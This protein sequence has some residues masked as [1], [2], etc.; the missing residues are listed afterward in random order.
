M[1]HT[2]IS[3]ETL[4]AYALGELEEPERSRVDLHV[5]SNARARRQVEEV[6]ATARLLREEL[7]KEPVVELT[8]AQR[9]AIAA[10]P[11]PSP[12]AM[13]RSRWLWSGIAATLLLA[14]GTAWVLMPSLNRAREEISP[15][16]LAAMREQ[17]QQ[18]RQL[19]DQ[20]RR[21][22]VG[23]EE[24]PLYQYNEFL[25]RARPTTGEGS[26]LLHRL[27]PGAT[28]APG[29]AISA[30]SASDGSDPDWR[31]R[32]TPGE[33]GSNTEAYGRIVD[34]GFLPVA[35]SPLSTF[36]I[37]VD[38]ASYSNVRRFLTQNALPPKDAVRIEEMVNY[39]PYSYAPPKAGD[40][41]PFAAHIEVAGC[42]WNGQNRLVRIGLKGREIDAQK[43]PPTNL[44][45]LVDVSGSMA[46]DNKLP[47]VKRGLRMLVERLGENDRVAIVVYAG[48][49]GTVL[50]ST[51]GDQ[52]GTIVGAIEA[53]GAGGST[54]GAGGIEAAYDAAVRNF[55]P[56]GVNRVILCT[57][58]DFNVGITDIESL[59]R[60]I[61]AKA[62]T[63]VFLSVLGFGMGNLKDATMEKLADKGNGNYAYVDT[64]QEAR[65]VLV[66]QMSG[67]LVTIA[68]DVKV[69]VE[70][71]PAA[72][73]SYRL[74]GYENRVLAKEDF[75]DD[76]KDAGEIGAGHTVTALY[77]VVPAVTAAGGSPRVDPLKYQRQ[78]APEPA[79]ATGSAEMLTVKLRYK[80]PDGQTSKLLEF[81]LTDAGAAFANASEDF[82]FA[83]A[84][85][86]F[87][88]VLR[89]SP[90]QGTATLDDA[91]ELGQQ[92]LGRDESGYR[93]EFLDLVRKAK[94]LVVHHS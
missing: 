3:D 67:T 83:S 93:T 72:V 90:H 60:L 82:K 91:L 15:K 16:R 23:S 29:S 25:Q 18:A 45:F 75:N 30:M 21:Q 34:N 56:K 62:K 77:E 28:P 19:L 41:N 52:K 12:P 61:E 31:D 69:Q 43:R 17:E 66:E 4:T 92:G 78:P 54:N 2:D 24:A 49:S 74:I 37:D 26:A 85:A 39:F 13:R 48:S 27:K 50:H 89:E 79:P 86:A 84:V 94:G 5:A 53:L 81:P 35:S 22:R 88:M 47:L 76:T 32:F 10:R 80:E 87:G 33:T 71:N 64:L 7:A 58:G 6:R 68:K 8:D 11:R 44:V 36:S 38:T 1:S 57:D 55:I 73:S 70:F 51:T 14:C 42:P 46:P 20:Q 63:G 40:A 65:K 9:L 59:T